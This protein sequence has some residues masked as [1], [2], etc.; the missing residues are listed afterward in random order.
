[1]SNKTTDQ[2]KKKK[3]IKALLHELIFPSSFVLKACLRSSHLPL[4]FIDG[5]INAS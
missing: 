5:D 4:L 2:N 3:L 1:M